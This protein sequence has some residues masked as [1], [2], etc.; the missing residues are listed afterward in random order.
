M[1]LPDTT[2]ACL[3]THATTVHFRSGIYVV[4]FDKINSH[5]FVKI[6]CFFMNN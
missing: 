4:V 6:S 1:I 5:L 2:H 3:H